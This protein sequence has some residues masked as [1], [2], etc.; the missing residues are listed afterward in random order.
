MSDVDEPPWSQR[1]ERDGLVERLPYGLR[2]TKLWHAALARAAFR[3]FR[4]GHEL[5][6][7]RVPIAEALLERYPELDIHELANAV[8]VMYPLAVAE[9]SALVTDAARHNSLE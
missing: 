8:R 5:D 9:M 3:L 4:R 6:D 7:F 2:T 1:L